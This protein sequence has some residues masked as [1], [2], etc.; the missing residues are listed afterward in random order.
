MKLA[1]SEFDKNEKSIDSLTAKIQ[2]L[3]KEIDTQKDKISTLEKALANASNSFGENDRRTQAWVVQL[4][5]AKA[6]LNGMERELS[7][8]EKAIDRMSDKFKKS[9]NSFDDFEKELKEV[10]F[11][12]DGTIKNN[13]PINMTKNILGINRI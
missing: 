11:W 8:N 4:N 6:E 3:N 5:N 9:E 13:Q 1:T 2:V 12:R 7:Q 10:L